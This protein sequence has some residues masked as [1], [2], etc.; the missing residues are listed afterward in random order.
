VL[1]LR[2]PLSRSFWRLVI[3]GFFITGSVSW[4]VDFGPRSWQK[5]LFSHALGFAICL[6]LYLFSEWMRQKHVQRL[7][8]ERARLRAIIAQGL[9][10]R[11]M[12]GTPEEKEEAKRAWADQNP[13]QWLH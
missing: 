3:L 8:F 5:K 6:V 13:A 11:M 10:D 2:W 4:F 1:G 7:E 9:A 12:F